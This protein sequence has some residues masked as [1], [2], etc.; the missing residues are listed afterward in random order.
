[1]SCL[2]RS[3]SHSISN[4]NEGQLRSI[5]V[6]FLE[7]NPILILPDKKASEIVFAEFPN[8]KF[9][10]Y[11]ERM[12]KSNTWGGAVEIKAFCELFSIQVKVLVL[13]TGQTITFYPNKWETTNCTVNDF[14]SITISWNGYHYEPIS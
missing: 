5:L 12:K 6:D 4:T 14:H 2:F 3:L 11:L 13:E 1:M 8:L 10:N 7:K 9:E